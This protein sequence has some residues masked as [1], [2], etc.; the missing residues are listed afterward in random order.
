MPWRAGGGD[1]PPDWAALRRRLAGTGALLA[2][3]AFGLV[4]SASPAS[5]ISQD[6]LGPT[7]DISTE[8]RP[9]G[10]VFDL[11]LANPG[12]AKAASFTIT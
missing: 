7:A 6:P 10:G 2:I 5:A 8:C 4:G 11:L 12:G 9:S 3:A 1:A